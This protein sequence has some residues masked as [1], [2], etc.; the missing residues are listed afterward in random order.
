M[1]QNSNK[2]KRVTVRLT[3]SRY[4]ELK[5]YATANELTLSVA[6]EQLVNKGLEADRIKLATHDDIELIIENIKRQDAEVEN[7]MLR[8]MD[9]IKNQPIAVQNQLEEPKKSWWKRMFGGED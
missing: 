9:A 1:A 4:E 6:I 2:D 7:Q 5:R 8:L 3:N